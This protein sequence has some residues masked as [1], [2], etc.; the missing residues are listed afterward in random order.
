MVL[1]ILHSIL[2]SRVDVDLG[3]IDLVDLTL[4]VKVAH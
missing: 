3:I 4:V 2:I 1:H